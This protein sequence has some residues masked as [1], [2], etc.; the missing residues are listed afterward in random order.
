MSIRDQIIEDYKASHD[1]QEPT[2]SF[3]RMIE[4][5]RVGTLDPASADAQ[6]IRRD[7][8]ARDAITA[9]ATRQW[10]AIRA[11]G[12]PIPMPSLSWLEHIVRQE[13]AAQ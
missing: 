5:H 8:A 3:V 4:R 12:L 10:F 9:E 2:G 1:G 11:E 7:M 13:R 6:R